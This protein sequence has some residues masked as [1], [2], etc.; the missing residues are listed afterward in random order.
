MLGV[1]VGVAAPGD[2][3]VAPPAFSVVLGGP[4][5]YDLAATSPLVD[6]IPVGTHGCGI[7]VVDDMSGWS[8]PTDGNGD[9]VAGCDIGARE[10]PAAP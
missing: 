2:Q 8:R 1:N 3:P 10:R 5:T 7:D 4:V 6:A 9:G